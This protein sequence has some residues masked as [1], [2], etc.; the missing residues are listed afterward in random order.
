M[1]DKSKEG[2]FS[3]CHLNTLIIFKEHFYYNHNKNIHPSGYTKQPTS[4]DLQVV[5]KG[6]SGLMLFVTFSCRLVYTK[7]KSNYI[8]EY[9]VVGNF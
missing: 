2:Y 1:S 4:P 6:R 8:H 9:L 5:S 3:T 7:N